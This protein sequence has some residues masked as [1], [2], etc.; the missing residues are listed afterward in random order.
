MRIDASGRT[1]VMLAVCC[2]THAVSLCLTTDLPRVVRSIRT[3]DSAVLGRP[4]TSQ[5]QRE[6]VPNH[7]G[8]LRHRFTAVG[9][10]T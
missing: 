6:L 10:S 5:M 2:P 7:P 8:T 4:G 1:C 3:R 9:G